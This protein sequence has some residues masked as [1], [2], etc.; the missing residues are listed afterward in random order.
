MKKLLL[1]ISLLTSILFIFS[2]TKKEDDIVKSTNSFFI[3]FSK[4][5][6]D[7]YKPIKT[8]IKDTIPLDIII[9]TD[10]SILTKLSEYDTSSQLNYLKDVHIKLI[11]SSPFVNKYIFDKTIFKNYLDSNFRFKNLLDTVSKSRKNL[12]K[13]SIVYNIV[14]T[15]K[16]KNDINETQIDTAILLYTEE[17]FSI[18][19]SASSYKKGVNFILNAKEA[20]R[21]LTKEKTIIDKT[22]VDITNEINK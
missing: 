4:G 19:S 9:K 21:K 20:R 6:Y 1:S 3:A 18:F 22:E 10:S 8:I 2:F 15:F 7:S 13:N 16:Y 17:N 14:H 11:F 5:K 12:N